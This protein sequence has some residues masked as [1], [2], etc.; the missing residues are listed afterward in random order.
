VLSLPE[1]PSG[2]SP[3]VQANFSGLLGGSLVISGTF[4]KKNT[5]YPFVFEVAS[6]EFIE[7]TLDAGAGHNLQVV[8]GT[9]KSF[10]LQ[11]NAEYW[12]SEIDLQKLRR[13]KPLEVEGQK[14][15]FISN[16]F[17]R[18]IYSDL[19]RRIPRSFNLRVE[20]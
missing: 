9:G 13:V 1:A 4:T 17:Q 11:F 19:S 10:V 5:T 20:P 8:D 3:K 2:T 6:A 16:N 18:G 14:Y 7:V 12:L 15:I